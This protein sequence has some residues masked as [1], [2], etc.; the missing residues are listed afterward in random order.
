M[1]YLSQEVWV[2]TLFYGL[3]YLFPLGG[4]ERL[5]KS[6]ERDFPPMVE[7]EN[8]YIMIREGYIGVISSHYRGARPHALL[9]YRGGETSGY[10]SWWRGSCPMVPYAVLILYIDRNLAIIS[11]LLLGE[12]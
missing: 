9:L 5:L 4:T 3:S 1:H 6:W 7:E 11:P 10:I 12:S 2:R 8:A